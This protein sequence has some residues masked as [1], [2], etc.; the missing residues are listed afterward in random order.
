MKSKSFLRLALAAALVLNCG[1]PSGLAK[2]HAD[3]NLTGIV[4][5][6]I[7]LLNQQDTTKISA[8]DYSS[9]S[10]GQII[11]F[12]TPAGYRIK[13]R[14]LDFGVALVEALKIARDPELRRRMIEMVQWSRDPKVR[15]EAIITLATLLDPSHK[16]YFKEAILDSKIGIRFAAVEALQIW[17]QPDGIALLQTAMARDLS[18]L[19]Q[20]YCAQALLSLGDQSGLPI[21]WKGLDSDSWVI[22]A[23]CARYLGDYAAPADYTKIMDYFNRENRNNFVMAE[24][25][26]SILKLISK[27][28]DKISY[29]PAT[30]GWK[31]NDE[32]SYT[33]GKDKAVEL[34][35][36]IIVPPQLRIP[37]SLQA[38]AQVNIKLLNLIKNKLSEPL[39]PLQAQD[40]EVAELNAMVTPTG[41]ALKTRYS[42]LSYLVVEA[43]AGTQDEVMR[44]QLRSMAQGDPNPLIR[45]SALIALSYNRDQD[46]TFYMEDAL[47]DKNPLLRMGALEAIQLGR[48]RSAESALFTTAGTDACP[49][50]QVYALQVLARFDNPSGRQSLL[51]HLNDPDWPARAMAYWY[52]GRYGLPEDYSMVLSRL[53][54]ETNPFVKAEI[55]LAALRLAPVE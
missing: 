32:V 15:A 19:M 53:P 55:V 49:A 44:T 24:M 4:Q 39:D 11:T 1:G 36:L 47:G 23:M 8:D 42:E 29:S 28:G 54:V 41:F 33:I 43:L 26:L 25:A 34:E 22:R 37:A 18:P 16:R 17:G 20:I 48:F 9:T 21:L 35:P 2:A 38:A 50:L 52:L 13:I 46:D 6:L 31:D 5:A 30:P 3:P 14:Y 10:L 40:P 27:K 51:S 12:A 45:A 7:D